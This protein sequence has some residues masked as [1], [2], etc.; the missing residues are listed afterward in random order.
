MLLPQPQVQ[1]TPSGRQFYLDLSL[2]DVPQGRLVVQL[3]RELPQL[4][5]YMVAALRDHKGLPTALMR[6]GLRKF[7]TYLQADTSIVMSGGRR[8]RYHG[9]GWG[10]EAS[11]GRGYQARRGDVVARLDTAKATGDYLC[12]L[13]FKVWQ[14]TYPSCSGCFNGDALLTS[15][16]YLNLKKG[17]QTISLKWCITL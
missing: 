17:N 7:D 11:R 9:V 2:N 5:E 8:P 12:L 16:G 13:Y 6:Q 1:S 3:N 10:R 14:H 4:Y 15:K